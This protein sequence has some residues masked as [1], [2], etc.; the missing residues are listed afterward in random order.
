MLGTHISANSGSTDKMHR[1]TP[2]VFCLVQKDAISRC[3]RSACSRAPLSG[4]TGSRSRYSNSRSLPLAVSSSATPAAT[5]TSS[6]HS[7]MPVQ[8]ASEN[9]SL[10]IVL[11]AGSPMSTIEDHTQSAT[12][13]VVFGIAAVCSCKNRFA[14]SCVTRRGFAAC[15]AAAG[16]GALCICSSLRR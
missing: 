12:P 14:S 8:T 7:P 1:T 5:I 4:S 3:M 11:H 13:S 6:A 2:R 16:A 9:P 10:K 15:S